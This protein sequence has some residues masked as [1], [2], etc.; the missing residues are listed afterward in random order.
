MTNENYHQILLYASEI[1]NEHIQR[2]FLKTSILD[3]KIKVSVCFEGQDDFGN[4]GIVESKVL[5]KSGTDYEL[6]IAE[7]LKEVQSQYLKFNNA[8]DKLKELQE[9]LLKAKEQEQEQAKI[10]S[11]LKKNIF[12]AESL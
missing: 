4:E 6:V 3:D 8:K 2:V 10:V 11:D 12:R 7:L 5:R 9:Q 1:M